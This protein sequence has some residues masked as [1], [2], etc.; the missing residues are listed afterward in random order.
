M[1]INL[2]DYFDRIGYTGSTKVSVETL[3]GIHVAQLCS[4]PFE[5]LAVHEPQNINN[6]KDFISLDESN[7]FKKLVT[8]KRGGYCHENNEL[9][10]IVLM[11]LG[12]K[13]DRLAARVLTSP[14]IWH[15]TFFQ[16]R[17]LE[18]DW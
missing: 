14:N 13:V 1:T 15:I 5:N 9:L 3:K 2:K 10:A 4:I 11:Q 8:D 12:F 6:A 17:Q 7:L 16:R 18:L